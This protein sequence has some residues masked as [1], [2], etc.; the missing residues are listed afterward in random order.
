MA[1]PLVE[2]RP[3]ERWVR[4]GRFRRR[5][6]IAFALFYRLELAR[7]VIASRRKGLAWCSS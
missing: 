3:L 5:S 2:G 7:F 1:L 4:G 6:Y